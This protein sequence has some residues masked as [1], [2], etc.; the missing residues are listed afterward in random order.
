VAT[1]ICGDTYFNENL[2]AAT[3]EVLTL[4]SDHH[5]DLVLVGPAFNAGRYGMACG[6]V[7]QAVTERLG[8]PVVGG[9][10]AENPGLELYRKYGFFVRT[11][12]SAAGMRE[13]LA[14]MVAL[15]RKLLRGEAVGD[16]EEGGYHPRGVR[17]NYFH[18]RRGAARAVELLLQKLAGQ[19][20]RTEFPMPVFDR[21]PPAPP[22]P[23]LGQATVALVTSG[24]I[25]PRGNPD[26][27]EASSASRYGRY[28]LEGLDELQSGAFET[29]HGG[30][31]PRWANAD[32]DRV[33]PLDAARALEQ[34]GVIGRLHGLLYSTV[35][36][37]TAVAT[38]RAFAEEIG[39][40]L[41]L[42]GVSAV[43]LTS[44]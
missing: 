35:G 23:D 34:E 14:A 6:A 44:T 12:A 24:G 32:P 43:V 2:E 13:A 4:I 37:G 1:V 28:S 29:A 18:A 16:P 10:Y 27:I 38:A 17:R 8:V 25:V 31:D 20:Y 33:V 11:R 36:N 19:N 22:V 41:L 5:P 9:M 3:A 42:A 7:A 30:Y 39:R 15:A 26:R 40:E 21:V